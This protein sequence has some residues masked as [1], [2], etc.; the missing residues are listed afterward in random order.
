MPN[1][2]GL[3]GNLPS[4]IWLEAGLSLAV[5]AASWWIFRRTSFEIA[6]AVMIV[7]GFLVS[8]HSYGYDGAILVPA[9]LTLLARTKSLLVKTASLA[10]LFPLVLDGARA[11]GSSGCCRPTRRRRLGS[12]VLRQTSSAD[13][14]GTPAS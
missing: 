7:G 8:Y 11:G 13:A 6:I 9:A 14:C 2:H 5:L 12:A 1:I 3:V 10:S 4:A